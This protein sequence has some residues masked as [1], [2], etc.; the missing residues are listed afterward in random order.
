MFEN[1]LTTEAQLREIYRPPMESIEAKV[2]TTLD[3]HS[4]AH[5]ELSPFVVIGTSAPDGTADV[6]PKGGPPGFV[7]V[8]DDQHLAIG[9]LSGNNLLDTL[10]NVVAGS[11]VGVIFIV[12]GNDVTL[13]VNGHACITTDEAVLDACAV[14]D[15]RPKT[16][17]GVTVTEQFMHCAKSFRRAGLWD[18]TSW[19]ADGSLA[20]LGRILSESIG[21]DEGAVP[22]VEE[23]LEQNY[24]DT[25]WE[26]GGDAD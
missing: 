18:P 9:D 12:P 25:M 7:T 17:I 4:R 5:I 23:M 3:A 22:A 16:A 2:Q 24:E 20:S 14:K 1:R 11:G 13:R 26:P 6:S 10:T 15:R 21:L 19:P 8:L